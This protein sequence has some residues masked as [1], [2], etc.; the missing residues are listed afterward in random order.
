MT[1]EP[2]EIELAELLKGMFYSSYGKILHSYYDYSGEAEQLK[3]NEIN[4][5]LKEHEK[6]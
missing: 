6:R 1:E 4:R 3:L 5:I 2:D